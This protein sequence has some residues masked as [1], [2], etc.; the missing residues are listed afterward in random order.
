[1]FPSTVSVDWIKRTDQRST[2]ATGEQ[3]LGHID[4]LKRD[5][6][7]FVVEGDWGEVRIQSA[8]PL[9]ELGE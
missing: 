2:D 7:S 4:V 9:F 1:M 6:N 8:E 3:D 5:G